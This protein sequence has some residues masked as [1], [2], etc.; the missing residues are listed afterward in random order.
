MLKPFLPHHFSIHSLVS[1][2]HARVTDSDVTLQTY[3]N[4]FAAFTTAL[5]AGVRQPDREAVSRFHTPLGH[6]TLNSFHEITELLRVKEVDLKIQISS[7]IKL[8]FQEAATYVCLVR[9]TVCSYVSTLTPNHI[10]HTHACAHCVHLM[11][12]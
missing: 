6:Y 12:R 2:T 10:F 7:F 1:S 11:F 3:R 5:S 9:Q 4:Y 8:I